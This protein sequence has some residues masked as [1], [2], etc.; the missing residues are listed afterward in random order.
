M[1]TLVTMALLAACNTAPAQPAVPAS[2]F[3]RHWADGQA[4]LSAYRLTQPRYGQLRHG[5][6]VLI[7]VTEDFDTRD[8][9]K[10]EKPHPPSEIAKVMK[11][12][13]VRTFQTG[14][15][16]YKIMTS[17]FVGVEPPMP[18]YKLSFS[19]QEWCGHVY[20]QWRPDGGRFRGT[21][22]S[23]FDAEAD[24]SPD[25]AVPEGGI[26]EDALPILLRGLR[27]DFLL[28]GG[29]K[30][31]PLFTAAMQARLLHKPA[32]F[33]TATIRRS[34]TA[35]RRKT[36]L[37]EVDAFDYLVDHGDGRTTTF[38]IESAAP[39]RILG[40][41]SSDGE[42]AEILGSARRAYWKEHDEGNEA[43]LKT[44]GL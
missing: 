18:L 26:T 38:T 4:E 23:Y 22:H 2:D 36:A 11:L 16:D 43:F 15:Y 44:L 42:R 30:K 24:Q 20:Q 10:A 33:V 1:R 32:R 21:L 14:I 35:A 40:W 6:A 39:H 17:V 8:G 3:W 37:G 9:V 29:E 5:K 25:V 41:V 13:A 19:A 7:F 31:V 28:P 34:N 12:N 27:G